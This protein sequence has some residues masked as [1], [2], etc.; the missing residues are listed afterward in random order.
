MDTEACPARTETT[1][2]GSPSISKCVMWVCL[3]PWNVMRGISRLLTSRSNSFVSAL[4]L[5]QS[6][7]KSKPLR[8]VRAAMAVNLADFPSHN[9][10]AG[11]RLPKT[12]PPAQEFGG[13]DEYH[14][15][16]RER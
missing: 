9:R 3:S 16:G 6:N 13:V 8:M 2:I 14:E 7:K 10:I 12:P 15:A 4:G 11:N 1:L 5:H